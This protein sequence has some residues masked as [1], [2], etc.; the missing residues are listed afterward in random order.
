VGLVVL[1][2]LTVACQP[3][4]GPDRDARRGGDVPLT[5][6]AETVEARV[7]RNATLEGL[8]RENNLPDELRTPLVEAVRGVF[9]PRD[10]QADQTYQITRTLDGL[11][12]EFQYQIDADRLLRV[13]R[14]GTS[15]DVA[16][17]FSAEVVALPKDYDIDA[18]AVEITRSAPSL[19]GAFEKLGENIQLP[20]QLADAFAGE[21]DFNSDLQPG[22]RIEVLFERATRNGEFIGYGEVK[23]A[24]LFASGRRITAVRFSGADGKPQWFD[25]RGRSLLRQFLKSPLPFDPRVTSRFSLGRL[26]PVHG[27]VRPHYGVDYAA[28]YGTRV[29]AAAAGVVLVANWS[30]EAGRMVRIRHAGGYE[31]SYLHLSAFGPG[32]RPGARVDQGDLI[33]RVGASG[34]VT[35]THLDYRISKNG[36]YVNPT[37]ELARM[38][39]GKPIDHDLMAAFAAQRDAVFTELA[40]RLA[41]V[42][43]PS[44]NAATSKLQGS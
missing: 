22:D 37:V 13:V 32:I 21:I 5:R 18:V 30:G 1:A 26:H 12:R 34:T 23:G 33:G 44:P 14:R 8:L 2:G 4:A 11:F 25:D 43:A 29:N 17:T 31:T 7:P 40:D 15:A 10:L 24:V 6:D 39:P 27:T 35:A 16:T 28:P 41:A 9:N 19:I 36:Q 42:A 38:P 3:A 20:W